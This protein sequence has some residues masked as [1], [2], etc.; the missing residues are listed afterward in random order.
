MS[1]TKAPGPDGLS[2]AFCQQN[3]DII[4]DELMTTSQM[5]HSTNQL[6]P[7]INHTHIALIPEVPYPQDMTELRPISLCNVVY[8]ILAKVLSNRLQPLLHKLIG[9]W[10]SAFIKGRQISDNILIAHELLHTM[11]ANQR[12]NH[13]AIMKI[14]MSK[15]YDRL[16]WPFIDLVLRKIGFPD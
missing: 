9:P 7:R 14:D 8:R 15:A 6:D 3:W 13:E 1:P 16:E 11:K 12:R 2:P 10:Q 5:F 4:K